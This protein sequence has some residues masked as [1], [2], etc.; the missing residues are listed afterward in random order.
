M[1]K[2]LLGVLIL[3]SAIALS[4][5]KDPYDDVSE[6]IDMLFLNCVFAADENEYYKNAEELKIL[7]VSTT[8]ETLS[9]YRA[10]VLL[11]SGVDPET[12]ASDSCIKSYVRRNSFS[13]MSLDATVDNAFSTAFFNRSAG[14]AE[15]KCEDDRLAVNTDVTSS[16]TEE[17][18]YR[19]L[20][21]CKPRSVACG[22]D[23]A[24]LFSSEC[25]VNTGCDGGLISII[26][27]FDG[28]NSDKCAR[29][30]MSKITGRNSEYF[31]NS[32]IAESEGDHPS[33]CFS[34]LIPYFDCPA[35]QVTVLPGGL[36]FLECPVKK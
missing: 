32:V 25:V 16:E 11:A 28:W 24:W 18:L 31:E 4:G 3:M 26:A 33:V 23:G 6:R 5:R 7:Q 36:V 9:K 21:V 8:E 30:L 19:I 17:I 15:K 14:S 1:K 35:F 10:R 12:R 20:G 2:V 13:K 34:A 27:R 22:G 29:N